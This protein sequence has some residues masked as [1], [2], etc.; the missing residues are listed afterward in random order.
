MFFHRFRAVAATA[1]LGGCV[2]LGA[3]STGHAPSADADN[4]DPL[5]S[6]NRRIWDFDLALKDYLLTPVAQGYRSATPQFFQSAVS[7]ALRNLRSPAILANDLFEGNMKRA[8]QTLARI[9]L[10]TL[11]GAGGLVDVA[12]DQGLPFHEADFGATLGAWGIP[13]GPYLVLPLL[14][15]SDP[16]DGIGIAV[17]TYLDPFNVK[18]SASGNDNAGYIREAIQVVDTEAHTLDDFNELRKS[19]LD[20]YAAIRSL[21]QQKRAADIATAKNPDAPALPSVPYDEVEPSSP[22]PT[23]PPAA[24]GP[25][26]AK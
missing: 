26:K 21:Y 15:P 18:T 4:N 25:A 17:D 1:A 24:A 8:G 7:N 23:N 20:F 10:N 2:L 22:V 12:T 13:A 16:R 11:A 9:W 14:G 5:E 6:V 19:S 3:C